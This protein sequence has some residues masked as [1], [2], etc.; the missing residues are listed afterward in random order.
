MKT[1]I[2]SYSHGGNNELLANHLQNRLSAD[3]FR[4]SERRKRNRLTIFLDILFDRLPQ[5]K[6]FYHAR[7]L[8][9]H[10]ILVGPIWMGRI[11]SPLK[12]FLTAEKSK[13][14]RYS[15]ISVC[16]GAPNQNLKIA[17]SLRA[18]TGHTPEKVF[19]LSI[20]ELLK[21]KGRKESVTEYKLTTDDLK[22][23][24]RTIDD[25]ILPLLKQTAVKNEAVPH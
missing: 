10:Y 1:L 6:E 7:N 8:Y 25:F 14:G 20:T 5:I 3:L 24:D 2:I 18:V 17:R 11:A 19:E 23:F 9:E 12:A 16:G 13:V 22:F 21:Q 15:F 4:I